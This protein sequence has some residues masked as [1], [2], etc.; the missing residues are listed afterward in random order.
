MGRRA[1]PSDA[2]SGQVTGQGPT[3]RQ[4]Q[5]QAEAGLMSPRV[6]PLALAAGTNCAP[7]PAPFTRPLLIF[8]SRVEFDLEQI[9]VVPATC[10]YYS[11]CSSL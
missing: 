3:A 8:V 4:P 1:T 9:L 7:R 11:C 2:R 10:G 6:P 5:G